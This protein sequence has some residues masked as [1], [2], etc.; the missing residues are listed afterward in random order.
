MYLFE[1]ETHHQLL[2]VENMQRAIA[3]SMAQRQD[4]SQNANRSSGSQGASMNLIYVLTGEP[5]ALSRAKPQHFICEK[6]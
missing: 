5:S 4:L 6:K 2:L 3:A 1:R